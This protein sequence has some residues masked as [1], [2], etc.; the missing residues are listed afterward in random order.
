[1]NDTRDWY[2]TAAEADGEV[3]IV[4]PYIDAQ[5]GSMVISVCKRLSDPKNVVALDVYTTH[6]QDIIESTS[7]NGMGYA[8]IVDKN[9][10][11]IAHSDASF[12]GTDYHSVS[13]GT[14]KSSSCLSY[15]TVMVS[16]RVI[17]MSV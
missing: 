1:M 10:T 12:N 16:K 13:G 2:K 17:S 4:S 9:G 15:S 6:I 5:T 3:V 8:F 11:V 7:I 14:E